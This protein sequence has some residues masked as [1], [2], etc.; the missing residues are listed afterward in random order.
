ML[1]GD[2]LEVNSM[3]KRPNLPRSL[4]GTKKVLLDLVANGGEG[5]SIDQTQIGEEDRHE[6]GAP[7]ELINGNLGEDRLAIRAFNLFVEP[8]VKVV[9]RGSVVDK[10]KHGE[11]DETLPVERVATKKDLRVALAQNNS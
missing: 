6:N 1:V 9:A 2:K 3:D 4:A 8:V 5:I 7:Q 10:S 11:R